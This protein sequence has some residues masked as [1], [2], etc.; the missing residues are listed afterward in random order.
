MGTEE[1]S[2]NEG[3]IKGGKQVG[4]CVCVCVCVCVCGVHVRLC[5]RL[6]RL[7]TV[8]TEINRHYRARIAIWVI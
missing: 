8:S 1:E 7:C 2:W 3:L 5:K 6:K 4:A